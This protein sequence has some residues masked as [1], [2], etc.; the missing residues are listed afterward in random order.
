M[1]FDGPGREEV[2]VRLSQV[3]GQVLAG[4]L[5]LAACSSE[6]GSIDITDSP[7]HSFP[8]VSAQDATRDESGDTGGA[9]VDQGTNPDMDSSDASPDAWRP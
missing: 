2:S 6:D 7:D 1:R 3:L 4:A 5:L 9:R 8:D